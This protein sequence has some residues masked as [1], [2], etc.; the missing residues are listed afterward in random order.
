MSSPVNLTWTGDSFEPANR[1][2]ASKC[3]ER[4][5]VGQAYT[6]DEVHARSTATHAHYF[7]TLHD[8][9]HSLPESMTEKFPTDEHLRKYALIKTGYRL[10]TQHFCKTPAEAERLALAIKPY[11]TYQLVG[12]DENI[13]TVYNAISQDMRSMDKQTFQKSKEAVLDFCSDLVGIDPVETRRL[14]GIPVSPSAD[15]SPS[16]ADDDGTPPAEANTLPSE[17]PADAPSQG[18]TPKSA[19]AISSE[20]DTFW[21][22]NY[23]GEDLKHLREFAE[24]AVR[25][26]RRSDPGSFAAIQFLGQMYPLYER[27]LKSADARKALKSMNNAMELVMNGD[28]NVDRIEVWFETEFLGGSRDLSCRT[29]ELIGGGNG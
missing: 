10:E 21:K 4:F 11:D 2:W 24:K 19:G 15:D 17:A 13:V 28:R 20:P 25:E 9:W 22:F 5:V 6:L 26:A 18:D 29:E 1:F 3:D 16:T 27:I 7:A 14:A 12:T 23:E 8:I